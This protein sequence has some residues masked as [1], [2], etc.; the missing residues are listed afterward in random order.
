M[1]RHSS[2]SL[3]HV[4]LW[5]RHLQNAEDL[6]MKSVRTGVGIISKALEDFRFNVSKVGATN[7]K[8]FIKKYRAKDDDELVDHTLG[9]ELRTVML[10]LENIIFA[11]AATK[12]FYVTSERRYNLRVNP[13]VSWNFKRLD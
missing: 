5:L 4:G 13:I 12:V 3:I 7:L 6:R 9:K 10:T 2:Y 11:E 1:E 8:G